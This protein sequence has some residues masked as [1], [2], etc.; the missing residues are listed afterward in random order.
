MIYIATALYWEAQIFIS[1]YH[2]KKTDRF[3]KFQVFLGED[4]I[5][6]ITGVGEIPAAVAISSVCSTFEPGEADVFLSFGSC[7][8]ISDE[9]RIGELCLLNQ[10]FQIST[11]RT[12]YPDILFSHSCR[13]CAGYT[14]GKILTEEKS[15]KFGEMNDVLQI[16]E[17]R[18]ALYDMEGAASYLA[19]SYFFEVDRMAFLRVITDSGV[20]VT[21][22]DTK[23]TDTVHKTTDTVHE[24]MEKEKE[25]IFSFCENFRNRVEKREIWQEN[26][27]A[28]LSE[29]EHVMHLTTTMKYS[30]RQHMVYYLLHHADLE[31]IQEWCRTNL[32]EQGMDKRGGKKYF[33]ELKRQLY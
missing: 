33:E 16:Q 17:R 31:K 14:G 32:P 8:T 7:A 4:V 19:A 2:L 1:Q 30:L 6:M 15:R 22:E 28:F 20:S 18:S 25:N 26:A 29:M 9:N 12:F 5:L 13:E 3:H 10:I 27:E 21:A 24:I 23:M 11:G